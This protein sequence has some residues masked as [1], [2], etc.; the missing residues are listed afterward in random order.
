MRVL[1][2]ESYR[3]SAT[4]RR[5]FCTCLSKLPHTLLLQQ[6]A[7]RRSGCN[8]D[9]QTAC[10]AE[11]SS[12]LPLVPQDP[13]ELGTDEP[14]DVSKSARP[15]PRGPRP[16]GQVRGFPKILPCGARYV[17]HHLAATWVGKFSHQRHRAKLNS[18]FKR[19]FRKLRA[20]PTH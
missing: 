5:F 18:L 15:V 2:S 14:P 17:R 20:I 7:L 3:T 6:G 10:Q 12:R 13:E 8:F 1:L 19:Q 16:G 9:E 4:P 11:G